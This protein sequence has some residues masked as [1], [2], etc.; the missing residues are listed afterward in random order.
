MRPITRVYVDTSVLGGVFDDEFA[1]AS[2][3]FFEIA[4]GGRFQ[5]VV[6]GLVDEEIKAAPIEVQEFF[7]EAQP[8]LDVAELS[9]EA[10]A[11]LNAYI[12]AGV[13]SPKWRDDALHVAVA[14]VAGCSMIV[15]W[16]FKHIV[17]YQ[18]IPKYNAVNALRGYSAI[19]IYSPMEVVADED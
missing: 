17:H 2:R 11:L 7:R 13:V 3:T 10:L 12:D 5:L 14:T 19:A 18:K 9:E 16:N 6:S 15:S 4:R 8:M 1:E